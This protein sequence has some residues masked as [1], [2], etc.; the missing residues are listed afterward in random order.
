MKT[1]KLWLFILLILF[2]SNLSA[3]LITHLQ[4]ENDFKDRYGSNDGDNASSPNDVSFD[5]GKEG[6]AIYFDGSDYIE[7]GGNDFNPEG[8]SGYS[9]SIWVKSGMSNTNNNCYIGKHNLTGGNEFLFGYFSDLLKVYVGAASV[10]VSSTTEPFGT[11]THYV[12]NGKTY[13]T[14]TDVTVFRNGL[15]IWTGTINDVMT[16]NSDSK[17]WVLGQ[18]WDGSSPSDYFQGT[19][20][21][22]R[23]YDKVLT[24]EEVKQI[25]T[26]ESSMVHLAFDDNFEDSAGSYDGNQTGGV[27]FKSGWENRSAYLDGSNDYIEF[28]TATT[29]PRGTNG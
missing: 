10:T 27:I 7:V 24:I 21:N 8:S 22:L 11:W 1:K 26:K 19:I 29:D 5:T 12:V 14:S 18:E 28:G 17:P 4:F 13:S 9:I 6:R 15:Q 2:C 20:D 3:G 25:Y 16:I 23:F